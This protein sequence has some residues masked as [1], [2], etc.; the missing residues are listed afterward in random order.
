MIKIRF[1][2]GRT[3]ETTKK[4]TWKANRPILEDLLNTFATAEHIK[5][6][7]PCIEASMVD[8]IKKYYDP[9]ITVLENTNKEAPEVQEG[10]V[11]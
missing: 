2:D 10:A 9:G 1:S 8:L 3:A 11:Y 7:S 6:Y 5:G 4:G